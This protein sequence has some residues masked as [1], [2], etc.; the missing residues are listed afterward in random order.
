VLTR[1]RDGGMTGTGGGSGEVVTLRV[2]V[3][4][5]L[6]G[7]LV[8]GSP[9]SAEAA[10]SISRAELS[11]S[12]LRLEGDRAVANANIRVDGD[13]LGRADDRGR[14]RIQISGFSSPTCRISV[15]DGTGAVEATLSGCS[16]PSPSE[17][18]PP[19]PAETPTASGVL[20]NPTSVTAGGTSTAT[21]LLS[22]PA[23]AGGTSVALSSSD[24]AVAIV[25]ATSTVSAGETAA[26]F[27]VSSQPVATTASAAISATAGGVTRTATLTVTPT[28]EPDPPPAPAISSLQLAPSTVA[29]GASTTGTVLL[30]SPAP[31]GG[32][33]VAL[34][35]SNP[36]LVSMPSSV[37]VAAGDTT[38][39][40][41]IVAA[42]T[43]ST[44][45]TV[46][47]ATSGGLTR[48]AVLTVTPPPSDPSPAATSLQ[49]DP[50]VVTASGSSTAT[51]G[52]SGPA[53]SGGASV[54]LSSSNTS[55][56]TVPSSVTVPAG[57]TDATF[58]VT[59]HAVASTSSSDISASYGGSSRTATL[60]VAPEG[61]TLGSLTLSPTLVLGGQSSTGTVT[62]S[63]GAPSGGAVVALSSSN[64]AR[65]TVPT[66]VTVPSG[67]TTASFT[68][69]TQTNHGPATSV[70]I[71]AVYEG[72]TRSASLTVDRTPEVLS[73]VSIS[74]STVTGGETSQGTVALSSAQTS[75]TSVALASTDTSVASVPISVTVPAGQTSATFTI[76]T[77]PVSGTGTFSWITATFG[78]VERGA[79]INVNPGAPP[80]A[81]AIT[82]V[83]FAPADVGGG[84]A[85]TGTVA[86]SG[87][88][89]GAV[90]ELTS[91]HPALVQVPS[92]AVVSPGTSSVHFPVTTTAVSSDTEVTITATA[93]CC[94]ATGTRTGTLTVT[95][96]PPPPADDVQITRAR[97]RR[98]ILEVEATST[99]PNAIVS[100]HTASGAFLMRLNNLGG[101]RYGGE[102]AWRPP[103]TNVDVTLVV[104]SNFGG[105]DTTVVSDPQASRCRADL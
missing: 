100:V 2:W 8:L 69:S 17:P 74:P 50:S 81:P 102:R 14:F 71:S 66:S 22:S 97:L 88:P 104:S 94:G 30:A 72:V 6:V 25:P 62:L 13:V 7:L 84:G 76:V 89:D 105:S 98:C 45:Q 85:A 18:E 75:D 16:P 86:L 40:F 33:S 99:D 60:T 12:D 26:T 42:T 15:D 29:S 27:T 44:L 55:V 65:A 37:T 58:S 10:V 31:A 20:L 5:L 11:G 21:V 9:P 59:T 28:A 41:T 64:T 4:V 49:L 32:A 80:S 73:S 82:S 90:I 57:A 38:A 56:A 77:H 78:G 19:P 47:S 43:S 103:G 48:S 52:L 83:T 61:V 95:T 54:A 101:G 87:S 91:S 96:D 93:R 1:L 46:I 51:V 34:A 36:F 67:A 24:T 63:G 35:A 68:V 53:P 3:T 23:P 70:P 92:E 79:S 39:T